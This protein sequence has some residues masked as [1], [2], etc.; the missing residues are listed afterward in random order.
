MF[1]DLFADFFQLY[2]PIIIITS[3]TSIKR[4]RNVKISLWNAEVALT[5][6]L[7]VY[8]TYI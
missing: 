3:L 5:G 6:H 7:V 1:S 8:D 2:L 4:D